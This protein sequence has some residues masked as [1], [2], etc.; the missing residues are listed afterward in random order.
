M[1]ARI[2]GGVVFKPT[3]PWTP[4]VTALLRHLQ[5][6]G[7]PGAPR[8][9]GA[10]VTFVPGESPHPHAW[11]DDALPRVGALLRGLHDATASFTPPPGAVWQP[12]WLRDLGGDDPVYGHGDT[13]PWNIVGRPDAFIDWEFA[14]PV[15][16]LWELAQTVWLNAQLVDDDVAERQG[17]ADAATRAEHA[18]AIV[19][20]YALPA[21]RR[22]DLVERLADVAAHAARHEAVNH[23]VTPD[24]TAAVDDDGYPILWGI[25]W[26]AR[27]ASWIAR[28]RPLLRRALTA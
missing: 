26:R 14:G 7:Y 17:L 11:P 28:H 1:T 25:A 5:E 19:D 22:A 20:G 27:S 13:G 2:T 23:A 16:R 21:A 18:R 10:G 24:S 6:Q 8:V 15:D 12:S 4:A 9:A 3:G